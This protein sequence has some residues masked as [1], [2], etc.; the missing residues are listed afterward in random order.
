MESGSGVM[1]IDIE[2]IK[3]FVTESN[4]IEGIHREPTHEEIAAT[5]Q[6]LDGPLTYESVRALQAVYAPGKPIRDRVGMNVGVGDYVAPGGGRIIVISLMSLCEKMG[7]QR[8]RL[9]RNPWKDHLT[10]EQLHPFMDGNGRTGR[11]IWAWQM[12]ALGAEPFALSFLHNFYY[13]TL[14]NVP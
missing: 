8:Y 6:F 3:R 9:R 4:A 10:F 11:A 2:G 1:L 7:L 5:V 13:Q 14:Q 12:N